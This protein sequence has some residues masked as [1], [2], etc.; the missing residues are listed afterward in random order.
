[1]LFIVIFSISVFTTVNFYENTYK[2]W[3]AQST[4]VEVPIT[5]EQLTYREPVPSYGGDLP[6]RGKFNRKEVEVAY[7]Y[8][9]EGTTYTSTGLI[10]EKITGAFSTWHHK[11]YHELKAKQDSGAP[12]YAYLNPNTPEKAYLFKQ[13]MAGPLYIYSEIKLLLLLTILATMTI[14]IITYRLSIY[15]LA[16]RQFP[17]QPWMWRQ[18]WVKGEV[19]STNSTPGLLYIFLIY[20]FI[21]LITNYNTIDYLL[22]FRLPD[23]DAI[24]GIAQSLIIPVVM[25]LVL[26][27]TYTYLRFSR[28]F[29][30]FDEPG[31]V[32]NAFNVRVFVRHL[33]VD[34]M[35]VPIR[36]KCL[37]K[38]NTPWFRWNR[39]P[40]WRH[41]TEVYAKFFPSNDKPGCY[42]SHLEFNI[43]HDVP[44][45]TETR[46]PDSAY[47]YIGFDAIPAKPEH[48]LLLPIPVRDA[49][50]PVEMQ[51]VS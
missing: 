21:Y 34:V 16:K 43:P 31:Q 51:A 35:V 23:G 4:W 27:N 3:Q 29:I 10:P 7:R 50:D 1:M 40:W 25:I 30:L 49:E 19:K 17:E 47:W 15:L 26:R 48:E 24:A 44:P 13:T 14:G 11:T 37:S 22:T 42:E 36:L 28:I 2:S 46:D 45:T 41:N 12:L 20:A 8:T 6:D 39:E 38:H 5:L 33:P 32:G 18:N 9:H